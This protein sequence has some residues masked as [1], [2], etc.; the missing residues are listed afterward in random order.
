MPS[1]IEALAARVEALRAEIVELD[2][3]TEPT[4]E[5]NARFDAAITEADEAA[6]ALETARAEAAELAAKRERIFA[7]DT[8]IKR[9]AGFVAPNVIVKRDAFENIG[10]VRAEDTS[11]D[12]VERAITAIS[13]VKFRGA[14]DESRENV[15][16]MIENVDGAAAYALVHANPDYASA[17]SKYIRSGGNDPL[18]TNEERNA[19]AIAQQ[20]AR[21][22]LSTTGANGGYALPTLLDSTLIHTGAATKNP[23]RAISRVETGTQNVWHGVSVGNVTTA[24]KGEGSAFTDGSPTLGSPSVT[25]AMLT[26]YV[27]ASYE[28]FQDSNLQAQLTSVIAESIDFAESAAFATGSGSGA[29]KGVITAVSGTAGSLVTAT[30]R[31]AFTSAS[32]ADVF[33]VVNAAAVRYEDSSAWVGNKA[34][35]NVVRQIAN[36]SAAGQLLPAGSNELLGSPIYK[37]STMS[38]ATT[39]GTIMAILGDFSQFV[40][41]DRIGI[42]VEYIA[43]VVDGDG[44]PVGKRGLVAYKRVGSDVTD[45]DAFRLLKA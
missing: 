20:F 11:E 2:A 37:S 16:R 29:P 28:I 25:A 43:N 6:Q 30:T 23:F 14:S 33:A 17:I 32:V 8:D 19:V 18:W 39:S 13:E 4:D 12:M 27:T 7:A 36:P 3:I 44:L 40:I 26:A 10:S 41:Y 9:E 35:F 21:A 1:N 34:F 24:W 38:A 15:V 45:V 31:G 42:N 22:S 5:Q